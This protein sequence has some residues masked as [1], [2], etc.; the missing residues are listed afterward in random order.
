MHMIKGASCTDTKAVSGHFWKEAAFLLPSSVADV[1]M[2]IISK[3]NFILHFKN[4][5]QKL[6]RSGP[7]SRFIGILIIRIPIK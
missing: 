1:N 6:L 3:M 4:F 2:N 5:V 7:V